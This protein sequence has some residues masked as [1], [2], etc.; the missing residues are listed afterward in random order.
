MS[1]LHLRGFDLAASLLDLVKAGPLD[2][3]VPRCLIPHLVMLRFAGG[4]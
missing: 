2:G 4:S 3:I 1:I